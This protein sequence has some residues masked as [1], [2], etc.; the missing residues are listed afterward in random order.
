VPTFPRPA[1]RYPVVVTTE[2]MA[3]RAHKGVRAFGTISA[4]QPLQLRDVHD[5]KDS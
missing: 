2:V 1:K 3:L 5:P 4:N